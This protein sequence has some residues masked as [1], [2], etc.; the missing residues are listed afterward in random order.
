MLLVVAVLVL[1]HGWC[2]EVLMVVILEQNTILRYLSHLHT[3]LTIPLN[4][5][6]L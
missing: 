6:I 3:G 2:S 4:S 5:A 1:H